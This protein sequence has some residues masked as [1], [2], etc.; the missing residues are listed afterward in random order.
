MNAIPQQPTHETETVA[1]AKR[2]LD[3]AIDDLVGTRRGTITTDTGQQTRIRPSRYQ[4][5]RD[6][7]AGQQGTQLGAVARSMPPLWVDGSDWLTLV[8][9]TVSEWVPDRGRAT[10]PDRL[11]SLTDNQWRPQDVQL[12]KRY[13]EDLTRWA[14]QADQLLDPEDTHRWDLAARCPA[15]GTATVHRRDTGGDYVRQAALTVTA[16][17]CVCQKCHTAW[18]PNQ[19]QFLAKV[20]GCPE[21][22]GISTGVAA[23]I[24]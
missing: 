12:I 15:C 13:T 20:I 10:T 6:H 8:D 7:L 2:Q 21:I 18:A 11:Y 9:R 1:F 22:G 24:R 19:F 14:H 17:G 5:I 16:N 4:E 3:D 23:E